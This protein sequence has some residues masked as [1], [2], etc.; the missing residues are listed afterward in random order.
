MDCLSLVKFI[1]ICHKLSTSFFKSNANK[2]LALL[3]FKE[4]ID[5]SE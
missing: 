2:N 5:E 3:Y 4:N 1:D